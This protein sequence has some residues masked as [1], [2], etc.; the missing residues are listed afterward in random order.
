MQN[1]KTRIDDMVDETVNYS[2]EKT[3]RVTEDE[4]EAAEEKTGDHEED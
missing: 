2:I 3:E 1:A 4:N